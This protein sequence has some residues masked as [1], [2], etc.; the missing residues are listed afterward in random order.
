MKDNVSPNYFLKIDRTCKMGKLFFLY[1]NIKLF[2]EQ[3]SIPN[4]LTL[5]YKKW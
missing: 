4:C 5:S 3:Q 1:I 2:E